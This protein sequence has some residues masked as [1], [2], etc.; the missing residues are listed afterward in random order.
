VPD[1]PAA[2]PS[3]ERARAALLRDADVPVPLHRGRLFA[4]RYNQA[5]LLARA[6]SRLARRSALL[7]AP[8]RAHRTASLGEKSASEPERE[9]AGAFPVRDSRADRIQGRRVP[10]I[11]DV[12]A[13]GPSGNACADALLAAGAGAMD[14]RAAARVPDPRLG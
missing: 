6:L 9:V 14:V 10:L 5:A 11:D 7:D 12:L 1:L 4:H 13:S 3:F 2:P 8:R